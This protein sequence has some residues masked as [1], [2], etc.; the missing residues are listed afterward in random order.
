MGSGDR[1]DGTSADV[2]IP[3]EDRNVVR[4]FLDNLVRK[5]APLVRAGLHVARAAN[6][7][8]LVA[9]LVPYYYLTFKAPGERP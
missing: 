7:I 1:D 6:R 2:V 4:Y 3:V 9:R 8:G 5:N